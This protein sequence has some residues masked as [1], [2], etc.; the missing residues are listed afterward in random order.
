MRNWDKRE[1]E[2]NLYWMSYWYERKSIKNDNGIPP[3]IAKTVHKIFEFVVITLN[4]EF[5]V[6]NIGLGTLKSVCSDSVT[7]N[8]TSANISPLKKVFW[9]QSPRKAHKD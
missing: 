4:V 3:N 9:K 1:S 8:P 6:I 2:T 7:R 5:A